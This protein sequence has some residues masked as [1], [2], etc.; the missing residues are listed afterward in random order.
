[1]DRTGV[2]SGSPV[3]QSVLIDTA[4]AIHRRNREMSFLASC[5]GVVGNRCQW[6]LQESQIENLGFFPPSQLD[7]VPDR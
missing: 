4:G 5:V 3:V 7:C 6:W 2:A 1:M